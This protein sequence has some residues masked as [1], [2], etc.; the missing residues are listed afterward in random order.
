MELFALPLRNFEAK[1]FSRLRLLHGMWMVVK[2]GRR[3]VLYFCVCVLRTWALSSCSFA[4]ARQLPKK[5]EKKIVKL[6]LLHFVFLKTLPT[7]SQ[8]E[9]KV[10]Q[11]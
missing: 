6:H 10:L 9:R 4:C 1:Y 2:K 8:A 11:D 3:N 7:L 5:R